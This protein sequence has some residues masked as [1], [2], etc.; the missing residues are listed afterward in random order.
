VSMKKEQIVRE[1]PESP[2]GD[3]SS[4]SELIFSL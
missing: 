3:S 1:E 4:L 2:F